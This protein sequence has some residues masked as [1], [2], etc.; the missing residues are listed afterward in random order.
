MSG[1]SWSA[2]GQ[3][4][5]VLT[6]GLTF[7][8]AGVPAAYGQD[9]T[10]EQAGARAAKAY[11]QLQKLGLTDMKLGEYL[12]NSRTL[13]DEGKR[14]KAPAWR[15]MATN[16]KLEERDLPAGKEI[17][18]IYVDIYPQERMARLA[19]GALTSSTGGMPVYSKPPAPFMTTPGGMGVVGIARTREYGAVRCT[20]RCGNV[21]CRVE[22]L[23]NSPPDATG[24]AQE[25]W[26]YRTNLVK[27]KAEQI[28][29]AFHESG[30]CAGGSPQQ[31]TT[32]P[33]FSGPGT[34]PH[35]SRRWRGWSVSGSAWSM[36]V[37]SSPTPGGFQRPISS[38][39]AQWSR[40]SS[41]SS[42]RKPPI[43]RS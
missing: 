42:S 35:S 15:I 30:V 37:R 6:L 33:C 38:W 4:L 22:F 18:S 3:R 5:A 31:M 25:Y 21:L 43:S 11:E 23:K 20:F 36:T 19:W 12:D 29:Q 39:S 27:R 32:Q 8:A 2:L 14:V 26:G 41:V 9:I 40:F 28:H 1:R 24:T 34:F 16:D 10:P 13:L 7:W 17:W